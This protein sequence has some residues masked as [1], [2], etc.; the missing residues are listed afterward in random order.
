MAI[1]ISAAH[2]IV[3]LPITGFDGDGETHRTA[4][5]TRT[6]RVNEASSNI[7]GGHLV[8]RRAANLPMKL[9]V[10]KIPM[11]MIG[12]QLPSEQSWT[13]VSRPG[14]MRRVTKKVLKMAAIR[15]Q[16]WMATSQ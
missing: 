14:K 6:R 13:I 8:G 15:G 4:G 2:I 9:V 12:P 5:A 7:F 11:R 16:I 1:V 10:L 3:F